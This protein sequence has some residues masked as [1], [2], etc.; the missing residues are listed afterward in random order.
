MAGYI[1]KGQPLVSNG[2][3]QKFKYT[4]TAGQTTFNASYTVGSVHV[5]R[6]GVRLT[7]G[8][9]YTATNGT[10]VV[11]S[12][13]ANAGDDV[14]IIA[15]NGFQVADAFTKAEL[16]NHDL[17]SV[18]SVGKVS[19]STTA[20][21]PIQLTS[22]AASAWLGMSNATGTGFIGSN[23]SGVE[24][25]TAGSSWATKLAVDSAGRVTMPYQPAWYARYYGRTIPAGTTYDYGAPNEVHQN[26]GGYLNTSTGVF[27]APVSG[28]YW[29]Q[30]TLEQ[31]TGNS[32]AGSI[33]IQRNGSDYIQVLCYGTSYNGSSAGV[34]IYCSAGDQLR[35]TSYGNNG[36]TWSVYNASF[37]G[38][39]IG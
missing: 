37:S 36:V 24:I 33:Y 18:D 8:V 20:G 27:T 3:E 22:T 29:A 30:V 4:A 34:P 39:L 7:D 14:V 13:G 9:D 11:L 12:E 25:Q 23:G 26:N 15:T 17:V 21:T 6:T 35:I 31:N 38:Y 16:A 19:V 10:S 1:G 28:L 32:H 2:A 5:Y